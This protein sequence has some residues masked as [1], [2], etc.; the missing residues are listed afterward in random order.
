MKRF[1]EFALWQTDFD[2]AKLSSKKIFSQ[3]KDSRGTSSNSDPQFLNLFG[4]GDLEI[5]KIVEEID[6]SG[7][8]DLPKMLQLVSNFRMVDIYSYFMSQE[9]SSCVPYLHCRPSFGYES[10]MFKQMIYY[11]GTLHKQPAN[12]NS[13]D[14]QKADNL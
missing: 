9:N 7:I 11:F 2:I 6:I 1:L 13:I 12:D 14:I 3:A 4:V 5:F 8:L 10:S